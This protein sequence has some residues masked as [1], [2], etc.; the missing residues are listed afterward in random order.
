MDPA[1]QE[2]NQKVGGSFAESMEAGW[3][4]LRALPHA[5]LTRLSDEQ[6]ARH[7]AKG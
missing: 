6:I 3:Q 7:L 5:E 2:L 4:L 1:T